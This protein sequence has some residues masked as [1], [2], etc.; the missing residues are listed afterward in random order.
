M[1]QIAE[2]YAKQWVRI[3]PYELIGKRKRELVSYAKSFETTYDMNYMRQNWLLFGKVDFLGGKA[4]PSKI[5]LVWQISFVSC[6]NNLI[7]RETGLIFGSKSGQYCLITEAFIGSTSRSDSMMVA[8]ASTTTWIIWMQIWFGG[9]YQW[10]MLHFREHHS[11]VFTNLNCW[12]RSVTKI[13]I[14]KGVKS[15]NE[16]DYLLNGPMRIGRIIVDS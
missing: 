5:T 10:H 9:Y 4:V 16:K 3:R 11:I 13:S 6:L 2:W 8:I 15:K 7:L 14:E 1:Y 12:I